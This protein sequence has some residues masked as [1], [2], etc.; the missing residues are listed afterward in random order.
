MSNFMKI[1]PAGAELFSAD[2][3]SCFLQFYKSTKK[4]ET[5]TQDQSSEIELPGK[6]YYSGGCLHLKFPHSRSFH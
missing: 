1:N 2:R 3:Q 6:V 5:D 4:R